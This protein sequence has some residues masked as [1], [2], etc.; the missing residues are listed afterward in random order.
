[1]SELYYLYWCV[2]GYHLVVVCLLL[3]DG[4][5]YFLLLRIVNY[6][7]SEVDKNRFSYPKTAKNV[8][9]V[10]EQLV[11]NN[12]PVKAYPDLYDDNTVLLTKLEAAKITAKMVAL[13]LHQ[14]LGEIEKQS[15]QALN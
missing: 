2:V 9:T 4:E 13:P 11:Q 3:V 12:V 1:M 5:K 10:Y 6:N 8:H 15:G 14:E 7:V